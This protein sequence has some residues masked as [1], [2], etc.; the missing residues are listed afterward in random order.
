MLSMTSL[1]SF[2]ISGIERP[3]LPSITAGLKALN[4]PDNNVQV[5]IALR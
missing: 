5:E 3:V 1:P 2:P 4:S